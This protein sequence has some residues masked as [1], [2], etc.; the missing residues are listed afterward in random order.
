M[1]SAATGDRALSGF[2]CSTSGTYFSDKDALAE[3]YKSDF[4]RYNLKR[5]VAGLPP[6]TKEWFE[7]RKAQLASAAPAAAAQ[8]SW[9]D[10]LTGKRFASENTY[11]AFVRSKKYGELVRKSGAPAPEPVIVVRREAE[12]E[13]ANN[14]AGSGTS[15][16]P[17][18][19]AAAKPAGFVVRPPPG[20]LP[21]HERAGASNNQRESGSEEA[22]EEAAAG[23]GSDWE[24]ASEVRSGAARVASQ[25]SSILPSVAVWNIMLQRRLFDLF[26]KLRCNMLAYSTLALQPCRP[27][28]RL[29]ADCQAIP[30]TAC[31]CLSPRR[32]ATARSGRS[33]TCAPACL[34]P[35]SR[36]T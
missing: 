19:S 9:L 32:T 29:S 13:R 35:T 30:S 34:T 36:P 1:A 21:G 7:A 3:H 14:A 20:G 5:K 28:S 15:A 22:S 25:H 10:P 27:P 24:T 4:H 6:V 26:L 11:Q 12:E 18:A 31:P 33:G 8:R 2:Y 16:A 23:E 17:P